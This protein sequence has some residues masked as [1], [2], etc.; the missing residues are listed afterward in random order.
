MTNSMEGK[1]VLIT[2]GSSGIGKA[3]ADRFTNEGA[4]VAIMARRKELVDKTASELG[5]IGIAGD[6]TNPS[7]CARAVSTATDAF[8][9]LTTLVNSAGVIGN[10]GTED[11]P[12]KEWERIMSINVDGTV[13]MCQAAL[14]PLKN[15]NGASI[16]NLSSVTGTRPFAQVTAYCVSKAAVDMYT[17]CL[18]LELAQHN[19]RVN[20]NAIAPGVVVTNLHT[21]TGAVEDYEG[22]IA[23]S[24][25]T[26]PLG[27][28]GEGKDI[29]ALALYL[30]SD[31]SRW[32]TG[33]IYPLDGGR[34]NMSAR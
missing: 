28:V 19:I 34:A 23:R 9:S 13:L 31:E 24:K 3:I 12:R 2:G 6:I 1:A 32:A 10:G 33:A 21:V 11:T 5:V 14:E 30:A 27:F 20:A 25:E 4:R 16:V 22:F 26:H 29:A 15:A 17:R 18:A 7:D 8:G